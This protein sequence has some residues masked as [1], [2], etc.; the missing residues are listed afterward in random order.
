MKSKILIN[1]YI[2]SLYSLNTVFIISLFSI[3]L[4]IIF[5]EIAGINIEFYLV[6]YFFLTIT[7]LFSFLYYFKKLIKV[8]KLIFYLLFYFIFITIPITL[9]LGNFIT[10]IIFIK[11]W[12]LFIP[13]CFFMIINFKN[14]NNFFPFLKT[15]VYGGVIASLYVCF[16]MVNKIFNFFPRFNQSIANYILNSNQKNF[17]EFADIENFNIF[18][19]IRPIGL[20]INLVSGGFFI[21]S[22]FFIILFSGFRFFKSNRINLLMTLITYFGLI[23]STSRQNIFGVNFIL[24]LILILVFFKKS[25][26]RAENLKSIKFF[27]FSIFSILSIAVFA[28]YNTDFG[29]LIINFYS[30]NTGGSGTLMIILNDLLIFFNNLTEWFNKYPF[31]FFFGIGTYTPDYPGIY[32]DL[33]P[34]REL[35]F[36][37][38]ILY[39]FGFFGFIIFWRLFLHALFKSWKMI[40]KLRNN[41]N[42]FGDLYMSIFFIN[43]LFILSNIHYSPIG[44]ASNFIIALI[45][46]FLVYFCQ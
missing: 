30:G 21:G 38:D 19:M 36:L 26:F 40:G 16:E 31:N 28:I 13:I 17:F 43:V 5:S 15:V 7:L 37:F 22:V 20:D 46:L 24:F 2:F 41:N 27:L 33:P 18:N 45:P 44:L 25:Y 9:F 8:N 35:H 39:T 6:T 10:I 14:I 34:P 32:F 11:N 42:S 23:C 3:L 4:S 12:L 1:N 29:I